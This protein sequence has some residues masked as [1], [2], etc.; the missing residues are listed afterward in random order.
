M[1]IITESNKNRQCFR[2]RLSRIMPNFSN[3]L[4]DR[5]LSTATPAS[6]R[7]RLSAPKPWL[8]TDSTASKAYPCPIF[9]GI[10]FNNPLHFYTGRALNHAHLTNK[11]LVLFFTRSRP[12]FFLFPRLWSDAPR[13]SRSPQAIL[14][15]L[16]LNIATLS[17]LFMSW[18]FATSRAAIGHRI[19]LSVSKIISQAYHT[20]LQAPFS[21]PSYRFPNA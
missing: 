16:S 14:E 19:N 1:E 17:R 11:S 3:N 6:T 7:C 2:C 9:Q 21:L 15:F 5:A 12:T 4:I 20:P 10:N 13:T 18:T 8:R